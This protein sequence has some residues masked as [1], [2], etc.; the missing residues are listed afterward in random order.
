MIL[1]S[2]TMLGMRLGVLLDI[3]STMSIAETLLCKRLPRM[4][5][6]DSN[7]RHGGAHGA[8]RASTS[9]ERCSNGASAAT[10]KGRR[11]GGKVRFSMSEASPPYTAAPPPR[12]SL[13]GAPPPYTA[14]PP[15]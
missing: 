1:R 11:G 13:R 8:G 2:L 10:P 6:C 5:T 3:D 15:C 14:A 7:S 12:F 9:S 4:T